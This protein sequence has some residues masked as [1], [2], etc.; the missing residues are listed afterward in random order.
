MTVSVNKKVTFVYQDKGDFFN[1]VCLAAKDDAY[2][3]YVS[4]EMM[5]ASPNV[6]CKHR[7]IVSE[8]SNIILRKAKNII[9]LQAML[10]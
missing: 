10:H 2:A 3:N 5:S 7:I 6:I 4:T 8:A 1:D 9:S